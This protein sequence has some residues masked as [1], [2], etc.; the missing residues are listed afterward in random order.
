MPVF[1]RTLLAAAFLASALTSHAQTRNWTPSV[2]VEV[3]DKK[4]RLLNAQGKVV[5]DEL[6]RFFPEDD[7]ALIVRGRL[8]GA[9]RADG[10]VL[11]KP[12]YR[13]LDRINDSDL[14]QVCRQEAE[15]CGLVDRDGKVLVPLQNMNFYLFGSQIKPYLISGPDGAGAY[16]PEARRWVVPQRYSEMSVGGGFVI[17][18]PPESADWQ[19]FNTEGR[20]VPGIPAAS[21][22]SL[23]TEAERVVGSQGVFDAQGKAWVPPGRYTK[24]AGLGQS[25]VVEG[26]HGF[27][28]I[29]PRGNELAAP[30][31]QLIEPLQS[32][33]EGWLRFVEGESWDERRVGVMDAQG[34]V[35]LPARW[36]GID[37]DLADGPAGKDSQLIFRVLKDGRIGALDAGGRELFPAKFESASALDYGS[38]LYQVSE[39]ERTGVCDFTT[40]KCP[41]PV[42]FDRVFEYD[43]GPDPLFVVSLDGRYGLMDAQGNAVTPLK[44]EKVEESDARRGRDG[45]V[46]FTVTEK[47]KRR[48]LQVQWSAGAWHVS[49]EP[50]ET[51]VLHE[52]YDGHPMASLIR[53]VI[54]ARY[55]PADLND[56]AAISRA[57]AEGRLR[58][59]QYPSIQL[60][61]PQAYALFE[62]FPEADRAAHRLS[63]PHCR[64]PDG[65][66]LLIGRSAETADC[67]EANAP[68]MNFTVASDGSATCK[69]CAELK[70]PVRW[71]RADPPP[72]C[73]VPAWSQREAQQAYMKWLTAFT[74]AMQPLTKGASKEQ[75]KAEAENLRGSL[76]L[77]SR[78]TA[79]LVGLTTDPESFAKAMQ[80]DAAQLGDDLLP[81]LLTLLASAEVVGSGGLYPE[82]EPGLADACAEVWYLRLPALESR[83]AQGKSLPFTSGYQLPPSGQLQRDRYP[84]ATFTREDGVLKLVGLSR[85]L[86]QALLVVE[87]D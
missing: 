22:W 10:K 71:V 83:K 77:Q 45:G 32:E 60:S 87:A 33:H 73:T 42:R 47:G 62:L 5:L 57:Y 27:G 66:R 51:T 18:V 34:K 23:W 31:Y 8:W 9:V 76:V 67:A 4:I 39:G 81:R 21:D 75:W 3:Q 19:V 35:L 72:R 6:D 78:A 24:I 69:E 46:R 1:H 86:A 30:R 28:L 13:R 14:F 36:D 40:G 70:L 65:F 16:D 85:E 38:V 74:A 50:V 55:L 25:A 59:A 58:E 61:G 2:Q 41:V 37:L 7:I 26:E 68:G 54:E 56:D 64:Q 43:G 49:T 63:L 29:G 80:V 79:M 84:F 48:P 11:L 15:E 17:A 12:E 44:Y 53:P 82:N 20:P 52:P